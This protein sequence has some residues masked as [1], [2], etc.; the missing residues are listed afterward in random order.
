MVAAVGPVRGPGIVGFGDRTSLADSLGGQITYS[1][2]G[3]FQLTGLTMS[4]SGTLA[5]QLT[6]SY[7]SLGRLAGISRSAGVGS[8]VISSSYSY[9]GANRLT[10][11][12]YA[13]AT[14]GTPLASFAYGY[15]ADG[16]V[17]SYT[18]PE[19]TLNYSYD[20]DGEL[21]GVSGAAQTSYSYDANGNRTMSGYQTGPGNELLSDGTYTYTYD[22]NGNLLTKADAAGDVWSYSW[23]YRNRLTEVKETNAQNQV[24]LD[25][26]FQYDV[27]NNLIGEAV[28]GVP[29][30][31]TVYDGDTP[32]L[33]LNA[34]GQV[35][36][37][38]LADP[39]ALAMYW[40]R[41]GVTG[42][43][44]WMVTDL[45]GP[46]R[47]LVSAGGSVEDQIAY[48]AYGNVVSE[49][50]AA[51]GGRLKYAGGQYDGGL[52]LTLFGARWY[53]S[54]AGRW[55]SQ[56]PLEFETETNPYRYMN[57]SPTMAT[58]IS[59]MNLG[60]MFDGHQWPAPSPYGELVSSR[61]SR[62]WN[63]YSNCCDGAILKGLAQTQGSVPPSAQLDGLPPRRPS[64][65]NRRQ[66]PLPRPP[67]PLPPS[68][69]MEN[70]GAVWWRYSRPTIFPWRGRKVVEI[71]P[72]G[73]RMQRYRR[74]GTP[75]GP[76]VEIG[77]N[78]LEFRRLVSN[79][80]QHPR[81][82]RRWS[83]GLRAIF[84]VGWRW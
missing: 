40:A 26:T 39:N 56:D 13:D 74:D 41:V 10:G 16:Q 32:Y 65:F 19:G 84:G 28:N 18:D 43:A 29:Q 73:V 27:N 33:D 17:T 5:A 30:R 81:D 72:T 2:N 53:N 23:D 76:P 57:N 15:N 70:F 75:F 46:V 78:I 80:T 48:D 1:Y 4:V 31:Y 22:R 58:D 67:A 64:S 9:D 82:P 77:L 25:E 60:M 47:A 71:S 37:R 38:Y 36:E 42:Q 50:N 20:K 6:F 21:T 7:D 52:G 54:A 62:G 11:I 8:H 59:G 3:N 49:T 35:S 51:A 12:S 24:V 55:L 45:L 61:P 68:E 79:I 69:F 44:D 34:A 14:S 63:R 83:D 66:P